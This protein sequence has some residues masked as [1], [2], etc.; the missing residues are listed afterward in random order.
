M[1][2]RKLTARARGW[3]N[4]LKSK[5]L[6]EIPGMK[7]LVFLLTALASAVSQP[8]PVPEYPVEQFLTT[9][10]H[11]GASFSPDGRKILVTSD[12]SGA[13]NAWAYP[14][15]GGP[16]VQLTDSKV[17][18][19]RTIGYF[20]RDERILFQQDQG[21]NARLHHLYVQSPDGSVRDLTPME[22]RRAE[23]L[24]WSKDETS[25]FFMTN[26]RKDSAFDL[27]EMTLDGYE[28]KLLF[29]NDTGYDL[30]A[31]S[32][33]GRYVALVN[34]P[35]TI[36][37]DAWIHDRATGKTLP[38]APTGGEV[39][40]EPWTFSPDGKSLYYT[41][42]QGAELAYLMRYD[43]ETGKRTEVL[44][45]GKGSVV[46][47][48][49]TAD[50]RYFLVRLDR[51]A[52]SELRMFDRDMRP[53]PLPDLPDADLG[54]VEISRD[55][56]SLAFY[57]NSSAPPDLFVH[58]L[59]T[60]QT[61]QLTRSLGA[62]IDPAHLVP[63]K[64]ARFKSY[65]GVEIAGILYKPH[66]AS[67]RNKVPAVVWVHG[68]PGH[69]SR[70]GYNPF[71]QFLANHGYAIYAIN[72]RGSFGYGK[73]FYAM[74]DRKHGEADLDD[75]VASK[76]MLIDTGWVEPDRI[77]ILGISYGGYMVLAALTFRPKEFAAGVDFYGPSDWLRLL[78]A[79]PPDWGS[80]RDAMYKEM[81]HPEKDAERLRRISPLFHAHRIER[82]LLVF[83]GVND[84]TVLKTQSDEI[85]E[86]VRKKGVP[87]E[88]IVFEDEGHGI[89]RKENQARAYAATVAFLDKYLK[90]NPKEK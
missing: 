49:F 38:V 42:D 59:R 83:Q 28:R 77:G 44:R 69:Q 33:D 61:R 16:P 81:G 26:E 46:G 7:T 11:S 79:M 84:R 63:G 2:I 66:H 45:D 90:R 34:A 4:G 43:V 73:T 80:T 55:G 5:P 25:F 57:A 15:D 71:I 20:P 74:D 53:V 13:L 19:I 18:A 14:V 72:N 1:A 8:G 88:Y 51:D 23:F 58:D 75:C 37:S 41:S 12:R 78:S 87:V 62:G 65:D 6:K 50:A 9:T 47:A 70:I 89:R 10:R 29:T 82:P 24:G 17:N 86:A 31:V 68:G 67:P 48:G 60:G 40:E 27:Y 36:H 30:A 3:A 22:G 85:V 39:A 32:R 76:K 52:R 35:E 54:Q 21:G 64:V 56:R